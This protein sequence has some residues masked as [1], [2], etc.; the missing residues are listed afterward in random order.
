MDSDSQRVQAL[1]LAALEMSDSVG[2]QELL[3]RACKGDEDLRQRIN[4]L[5]NARETADGSGPRP[6]QPPLQSTIDSP[7][8][9]RSGTLVAG[10]YKLI[11]AIGEGG[12]GSIW[13]AEQIEPVRRKVAIKLIKAGMDS[14]QVLARFEAE[15]QALAMM[16]HPNIAKVFDG[17]MTEQGRPF[18]VMEYVK[19]VPITDYCDQARLSLEERLQLFIPVCQ[20]VQH[21]H[22]KG[23]IHRDLKPSN[24]LICVH[25]DKPVARV[26][27]FGLA[28]AMHQPLTDKS[29]YTVHG[30][31]VG[32]PLY[33]SPEQAEHNNLDV[34][35]RTDVYSLGVLLYELLTGTTPFDSESLRRAGY[36]EIQRIIREDTPHKPSTRL[37]SLHTLPS[38]AAQRKIEP[39]RLSLLIRG[40]LDWIVMKALEKDRTRRYETANGF[41]A[42]VRRFLNSEPVVASPPSTA[43]RVRKFIHRNKA[44]VIAA[45]LVV[46]I[47]V[48]GVAGTTWGM[49]WALKEKE[50]ADTEATNARLAAQAEEIARRDAELAKEEATQRAEDLQQVAEF[51]SEQ[52]GGIDPMRMG[53]QLRSDLIDRVRSAAERSQLGSEA[54]AERAAEV[55]RLIAG[56]DFTGMARYT[57]E[58][59]V[60]IRGLNAIERQ[61][62]DQPLVRATLLQS[63]ALT[64]QQLGLLE[65]AMEPQRQALQIRRDLLGKEHPDTVESIIALCWLLHEGNTSDQQRIAEAEQLA[66]EALETSRSALGETHPLTLMAMQRMGTVLFRKG[67][68][69]KVEPLFR[70]VLEKR[71]SIL[72]ENHPD[73]LGSMHNMGSLLALLG[74]PQEAE[75][76]ERK[77]FEGRR[78]VNGPDD[79]ETLK[80]LANLA[81]TLK[82]LDRREE[83]TGYVSEV[84]RRQ[85]RVLGEDHPHTLDAMMRLANMLRNDG[86]LVEAEAHM[87]QAFVSQRRLRGVDHRQTQ[88]A[89]ETLVLLHA[90]VAAL[91]LWHGRDEDYERLCQVAIEAV[92]SAPGPLAAERAAT[93]CSMGPP[94][95]ED[96]VAAALEF[97][98]YAQEHSD[99]YPYSEYYLK[100]ALGFAHFRAGNDIEAEKALQA[101]GG[102]T[103]SLLRAMLLFRQGKAEEAQ[104]LALDSVANMDSV[105][106]LQKSPLEDGSD[107]LLWL[108]YREAQH[109]I[110]F[111]VNEPT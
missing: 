87:R 17:G 32:T 48:L 14:Q 89:L 101:A 27:D 28:K 78:K 99:A 80:T 18:F 62:K 16:D 58:R 76:F 95:N 30:M 63:V 64:L 96:R 110:G 51:Q 59:T 60:F 94:V 43:Y 12:M 104:A 6:Q 92:R 97:A 41:A 93:L 109:L 46:A 22:Q 106:D 55:E 50:R 108:A 35:T 82:V 84:L 8:T 45:S 73:T 2:R 7:A 11:E 5:L 9:T 65:L 68:Y 90:R 52:L 91:H 23:I 86:N 79:P 34:D 25:D 42:D 69:E 24:I 31:M 67:E 111:K 4:A 54:V 40:D 98:Q 19:G 81:L 37:S 77:A 36:A 49:L 85:R 57:L 39:K 44:G 3:D 88:N 66:E 102:A 100:L 56:V 20:A 10:R 103:A 29:L 1:Y 61:F 26:I 107:I 15:R 71:Q 75:L 70:E 83:A 13:L 47:L 38:I 21:A 72:G 105:P 74:K 33:M 53:L